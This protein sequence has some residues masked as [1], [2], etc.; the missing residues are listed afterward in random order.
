LDKTYKSK[1]QLL[2]GFLILDR[3]YSILD[4]SWKEQKFVPIL[5]GLHCQQHIEDP[6]DRKQGLM[7]L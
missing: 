7:K 1:N 2:L 5:S 4:K 6:A 3:L